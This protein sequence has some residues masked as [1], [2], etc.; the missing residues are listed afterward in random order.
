M[1]LPETVLGAAGPPEASFSEKES[2]FVSVLTPS[3]SAEKKLADFGTSNNITTSAFTSSINR[4]KK[5]LVTYCNSSKIRR[6]NFFL[7]V[8]YSY[9]NVC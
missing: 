9:K 8:F 2:R 4:T 5:F 6:L 1:V 3:S 7:I